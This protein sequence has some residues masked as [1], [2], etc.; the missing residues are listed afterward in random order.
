MSVGGIPLHKCFGD[1]SDQRWLLTRLSATRTCS[2]FRK[3]PGDRGREIVRLLGY[4]CKT[5][6]FERPCKFTLVIVDVFAV[7]C[8]AR[9]DDRNFSSANRLE[10]RRASMNHDQNGICES[11]T[12]GVVRFIAPEIVDEMIACF[13]EASCEA[14]VACLQ[15]VLDAHDVDL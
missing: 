15:Q 5:L 4:H 14:A 2:L 7:P 9:H 12:D 3:C 6:R 11:G 13:D 10:S 8:L 1:E